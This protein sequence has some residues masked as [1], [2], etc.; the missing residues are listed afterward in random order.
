MSIQTNYLQARLYRRNW[1]LPILRQYAE[2]CSHITE[3]GVREV[4][5]TWAFLA[6][7]PRKLVSV[8]WNKPPCEVIKENL[9]QAIE[10]SEEAGIDFE[11]IT[12]DSLDIILEETDLLFIDTW[13]TYH[14]LLSE[15]ML[16][17]GKA[18]KYILAHDTK[19]SAFPGMFAAV[20]DFL[21][22]NPQWAIKENFD[23][24]TGMTVLERVS[25]SETNRGDFDLDELLNEVK[26]QRELFYQETNKVEST[27]QAWIEYK[28]KQA[29]RFNPQPCNN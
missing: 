19:P 11:F 24:Q 2:D 9:D 5:S 15:L 28:Q 4:F 17:S 20:E 25:D 16:H 27:S 10:L 1:H 14:Q 3:L 22:V 12:G 18:R 8:D 23:T 7:K 6:V 21:T 26:L 13:H 29:E